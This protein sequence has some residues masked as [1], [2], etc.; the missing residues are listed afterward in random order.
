MYSVYML[1]SEVKLCHT[2]KQ[3]QVQENFTANF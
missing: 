1:V 2:L 3:R